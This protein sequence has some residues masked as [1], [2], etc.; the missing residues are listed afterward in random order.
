MQSTLNIFI[1]YYSRVM[2]A[3]WIAYL[4]YTR[5]LSDLTEITLLLLQYFEQCFEQCMLQHTAWQPARM[6]LFSMHLYIIFLITNWKTLLTCIAVIIIIYWGSLFDCLLFR[7]K[8]VSGLINKIIY[9]WK[10]KLKCTLAF[11]N[12]K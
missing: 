8:P 9:V 7:T 1:N 6:V 10:H 2:Y 11:Y 5:K 12:T 4:R 3:Y